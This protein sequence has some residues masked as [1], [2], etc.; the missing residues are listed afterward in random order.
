MHMRRDQ[1]DYGR[2]RSELDAIVKRRHATD[3]RY[4]KRRALI[5]IMKWTLDEDTALVESYDARMAAGCLG[6]AAFE[7]P[8]GR[9]VTLAQ[10]RRRRSKLKGAGGAMPPPAKPAQSSFPIW[11]QADDDTR[12]SLRR[13]AG[14]WFGRLA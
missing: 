10:A 7:L 4:L 3:L 1:E 9:T 11:S 8:S 13:A 12:Q 2:F 6:P 5:S 14:G